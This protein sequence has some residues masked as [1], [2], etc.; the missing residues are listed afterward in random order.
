MTTY[1][2]ENTPGTHLA[3][4]ACIVP[5]AAKH[6]EPIVALPWIRKGFATPADMFD[7]AKSWFI[8][9]G[10]PNGLGTASCSESHPDSVCPSSYHTFETAAGDAESEAKMKLES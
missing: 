2:G 5:R 7:V 9:T 8:D 1:E 6:Y 4:S 10:C 3:Q